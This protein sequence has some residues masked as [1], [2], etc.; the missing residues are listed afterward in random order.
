MRPGLILATFGLTASCPV[1][2]RAW[3]IEDP[4]HQPCH[5]R[6]SQAALTRVGYVSGPGPLTGNDARLRDNLEFDASPYLGLIWE[7]SD[8]V[9]LTADPLDLAL[10][11][12]GLTGWPILFTQHRFSL[13]LQFQL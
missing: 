1:S 7:F 5:E 11:A 3:Q 10:P 8:G 12:P 9:A 4:I 13:G 2:A 6:L